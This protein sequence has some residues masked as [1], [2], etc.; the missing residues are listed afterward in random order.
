MMASER[1][2]SHGVITSRGQ[3]A[4]DVQQGSPPSSDCD[5]VLSYRARAVLDLCSRSAS[6]RLA[7]LSP[8]SSGS[9]LCPH[10]LQ[11]GVCRHA[12]AH[13]CASGAV[14][15]CRRTHVVIVE[16]RPR[17]PVA[18]FCPPAAVKSERESL[19]APPPGP[20]RLPRL[21]HRPSG[22]GGTAATLRLEPP[23]ARVSCSPLSP[24]PQLLPRTI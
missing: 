8:L 15:P 7:A 24:I 13:G 18:L 2:P 12:S 5:C 6:R 11:R 22:A 14:R 23:I 10:V 3:V 16:Q 21:T 19:A 17:D 1:A 4:G 20:P 9:V